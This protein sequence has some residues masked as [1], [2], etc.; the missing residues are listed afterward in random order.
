M[1]TTTAQR[2]DALESK[3]DHVDQIT[4]ANS[5]PSKADLPRACAKSPRNRCPL[6]P[7]LSKDAHGD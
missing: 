5:Q 1:P 7:S 6:I 4:K 3:A 2:L